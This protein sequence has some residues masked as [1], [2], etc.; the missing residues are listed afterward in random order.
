M[1]NWLELYRSGQ[2]K[3]FTAGREGDLCEGALV[4]WQSSTGGVCAG[5]IAIITPGG[6]MVIVGPHGLVWVHQRALREP[7][8]EQ[9]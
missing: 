7:G 3:A 8:A 9:E 4:T 6:W 2:W 5:Q 1:T